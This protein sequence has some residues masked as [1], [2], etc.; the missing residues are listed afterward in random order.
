MS[1]LELAANML[2]ILVLESAMHDTCC[3]WGPKQH[4][5]EQC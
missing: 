2:Y 4:R 3:C 5:H 1:D